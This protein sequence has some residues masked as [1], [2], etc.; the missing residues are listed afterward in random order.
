MTNQWTPISK[1]QFRNMIRALRANPTKANWRAICKQHR[2]RNKGK[3]TD[4]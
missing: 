4:K 3:V 2:E 1:T